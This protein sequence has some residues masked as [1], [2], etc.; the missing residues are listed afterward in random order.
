MG[1]A[2]ALSQQLLKNDAKAVFPQGIPGNQ[3]AFFPVVKG[4]GVAIMAGDGQGLPDQGLPSLG[5]GLPGLG[6]PGLA[7]L[8]LSSPPGS[9]GPWVPLGPGPIVGPRAHPGGLGGGA[10]S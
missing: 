3:Q 7:G 4:Q 5:Q 6:L 10:T 8:G 2:V 9:L 1:Q